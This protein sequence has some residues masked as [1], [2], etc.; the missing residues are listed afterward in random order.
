MGNLRSLNLDIINNEDFGD[1]LTHHDGTR[2]PELIQSRQLGSGIHITMLNVS[3]KSLGLTN[4]AIYCKLTSGT[5][6]RPRLA[7]L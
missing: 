1:R 2:T 5:A 3:G 6:S 7:N 4:Q